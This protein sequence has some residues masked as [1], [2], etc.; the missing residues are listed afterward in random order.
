MLPSQTAIDLVVECEVSSRAYFERAL[1]GY[2]WPGGASGPTIGIGY[3]LGYADEKKLQR[4]WVPV[5]SDAKQIATMRAALGLKGDKAKAFVAKH[6]RDVKISWDQATSVFLKRDVPEYVGGLCKAIPKAA[7]LP[8]DCLGAL[9]SIAYN[10]GN[11]GW[12][13]TGLRYKEMR[14]IREAVQ[15][16][17]PEAV[18][19]LIRG[20]KRIWPSN[21]RSKPDR[22]LRARRDREADL[23]EKGLKMPVSQAEPATLVKTSPPRTMPAVEPSSAEH[24]SAGGVVVATAASAADLSQSH[25]WTAS[26]IAVVVVAGLVLAFVAWKLVNMWRTLQNPTLARAKDYPDEDMKGENQCLRFV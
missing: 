25:A 23:F 7:D 21:D 1:S 26:E 19:A 8:P 2:E 5:V 15:G 20:M 16:D 4:D 14:A 24:G 12:T 9:F 13:M 17:H 18:P 11:G 10:R 3:D 6:K 22:G